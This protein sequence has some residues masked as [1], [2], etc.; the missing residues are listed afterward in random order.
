[1]V[2]HCFR[3]LLLTWR[4]GLW[5]SQT[6]KCAM[7]HLLRFSI[8]CFHWKKG[9]IKW[10]LKFLASESWFQSFKPFKPDMKCFLLS[11]V[12][13][14]IRFP[15]RHHQSL[16]NATFREWLTTRYAFSPLLSEPIWRKNW[17][18]PGRSPSHAGTCI[19]KCWRWTAR[20]RLQRNTS[21]RP[22]PS[23]VT[24][25]GGRLSAPPARW[26]F[27]LRASRYMH[28]PKTNK[29]LIKEGT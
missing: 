27:A 4:R 26:A 13:W 20:L 18:E 9:L 3:I 19:T 29:H 16:R 24:C 11:A 6:I 15:S 7:W 17:C 1:M 8:T 2:V 21:S 28:R 22:W 10:I 5:E 25:S 14:L 12:K 23:Y